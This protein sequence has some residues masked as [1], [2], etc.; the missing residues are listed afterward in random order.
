MKN[1]R[2][3]SQ[4]ELLITLALLSVGFLASVA[5]FKGLAKAIYVTKTKSLASNL[6][7]EK[8]EFMKDKS[9]YRLRV[10]TAPVTITEPDPDVLSDP[11]NYPAE[12][13]TVGGIPFT[14][15]AVVDKVRKN[16]LSNQ[17][18]EVSWSSPDTGLKRLKVSVVWR[19]GSD[20]KA[21]T[22]HNL[23]ENP[24]RGAANVIFSGIVKDTMNVVMADAVV[25]VTENPSWCDGTD[26]SGDYSF[27]LAPGTYT[28][29]ASKTG[30]FSSTQPNL[31]ITTSNSPYTVPV[32]N[33]TRRSS[34]TVTGTIWKNDHLVLSR[35]VGSTFTTAGGFSQ[36]YVEIFN[37]TTWTWTVDGDIGLKFQ[38]PTDSG[39]K[40]ISITYSTNSVVS[41]GFYLF[42][43]TGTLV[44]AGTNITADAT[45]AGTNSVLDFPYFSFSAPSGYSNPTDP[46]IIPVDGQGAEGGGALELY[47]I[48]DGAILDQFGWDRNNGSQ[49]APFSET[50]GLDEGF[51]LQLG[52]QYYRHSSTLSAVNVNSGPA[53]DSGN[54]N[55][56][57]DNLG[58][59]GSTE[60]PRNTTSSTQP[61]VAG[62]PSD[63]AFVFADDGMSSMV[64][65]ANTGSPPRAAF[66]LT[67]IAT[68]TWTLTA[69]SS[70][71]LV[72]ESITV[73]GGSTQSKT[74]RFL[75]TGTNGFVSGTVRNGLGTVLPNIPI[76]Y[77]GTTDSLGR[78][79]LSL[80]PG[81]KVI[82]ANAGPPVGSQFTEAQTTVN[83]LE[84]QI[85]TGVDF[86]LSGG[87][88][89]QGKVTSDGVNAL[90][91]IPVSIVDEATTLETANVLSQ[92]DG[93]FITGAST[94]SYTV[95]PM[96]EFGEVVTPAYTS[97]SVLGGGTTV[98]SSTFTVGPAQGTITGTV[99]SGGNSITT[100][101]LVIASTGTVEDPPLDVTAAIRSGGKVYYS[102]SSGGDGVYSL[103]VRAGTYNVKGWY[104]T[105]NGDT[106]TTT[107]RS[108]TGVV[109]TA[110]GTLTGQDMS[111]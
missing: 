58:S 104:T 64:Q 5:A 72:D 66:S 45:W 35:V 53:Y 68:G 87:G 99:T 34:G 33:L 17:L 77:G 19:E 41:G 11:Y 51:G 79:R 26:S 80:S 69:S 109:V 61:V 81:Y 9:Y 91:D 101:V 38:R 42:A 37:P 105:F 67:S 16:A 18:Q 94:G 65:A 107:V 73:T 30:Y 20:W 23:R 100:G 108:L 84:G 92:F 70:T 10:S 102:A 103:D 31:N 55:V 56:D 83:V 39:K 36:E 25:E 7:Q 88:K 32:F 95:T 82:V 2:G 14:R 27:S 6:A 78:Y 21:M 60:F 62:V 90:P 44:L 13:L 28:L 76:N 47:R 106:P 98:W 75:T 54:N 111:W 50:E 74:L 3:F 86:T 110:G 12:N 22:L 57:W 1:Q 15:Y 4:V 40:T 63:G 46:N 43:N 96:G 97:V 48:S 85:V 93:Y 24:S 71:L 49:S 29:R 8:I 89:I 59:I 52:E